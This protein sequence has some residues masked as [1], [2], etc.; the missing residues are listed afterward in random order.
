MIEYDFKT[1]PWQI[2]ER[3][4]PRESDGARK[5]SFLLRY[6]IL[7]P[8][9]HN[10]QPWKFSVSQDRLLLY[11][12]VDRWLRVADADQREMYI[13]I[14]CALENLLIAAQHF[15]LGYQVNYFPEPDNSKLIAS[16]ELASSD[17]SSPFR[18]PALF[19]AVFVRHTN[20]KPYEPRPISEEDRQALEDCCVEE[21][22]SLHLMSD[23][24]T[25]RKVDE[26]VSLADAIQLADPAFREELAQWIGEGVFGTAWLSAKLSQLAISY[27][28]LGNHEGKKD[29]DL[30]MSA[31][32]LGVLCSKENDRASQVRVGQVFE[33]IALTAAS[34][35]ISIQPMSQIVQVPQI[36]AELASLIPE[37][38]VFPQQPFRVGYAEPERQRSPRGRLEEAMV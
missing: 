22:I 4:F 18:H 34:L 26:L 35:R 30:L 7:A 33:R 21:G 28:A 8:S 37:A 13:S 12:N 9:S 5:L 31:P 1:N 2:I 19:Y 10:T 36:K 11:A 6:A 14:G 27:L 15:G 20:R 16:V 23:L 3:N 17:Q 29:W 32:A 38:D 25:R 24:E